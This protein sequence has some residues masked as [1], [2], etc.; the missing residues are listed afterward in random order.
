MKI[1][2]WLIGVAIV[3][4]FI[5]Y[6]LDYFFSITLRSVYALVGLLALWSAFGAFLN[7]NNPSAF[8]SNW[9]APLRTINPLYLSIILLGVT[10]IGSKLITKNLAWDLSWAIVPIIPVMLISVTLIKAFHGVPWLRTIILFAIAQIYMIFT[11][12]VHQLN[13]DY[14]YSP[15]FEPKSATNLLLTAISYL[16]VMGITITNVYALRSFNF[17]QEMT[18]NQEHVRSLS[19]KTKKMIAVHEAGHAMMYTYFKKLPSRFNI[20]LYEKALNYDKQSSGL[21]VAYVSVSDSKDFKEWEMLLALAGTRAELI[22]YNEHSEGSE[23][24]IKNWQNLAH[25]FLTR[26]DHK[27]TNQPTTS[28]HFDTNKRL[29]AALFDKHTKII[30]KFLKKNKSIMMAI[31]KQAMIFHS[32]ESMHLEKHLNK[33]SYTSD[34]PR[35]RTIF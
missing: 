6:S 8:L 5:I 14:L 1:I 9:I 22:A 2:N 21:V 31:A 12:V 17:Y 16:M 33:V 24:D 10:F 3:S 28:A 27:Y 30:D 15:L 20:Y 32:L 23:V 29:E 19:H 18:T 11:V 25:S 34:F 4:I 13:I 26:F 7:R 35:E